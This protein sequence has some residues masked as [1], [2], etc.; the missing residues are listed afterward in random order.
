MVRYFWLPA[1]VLPLLVLLLLLAT[2]YAQPPQ[3]LNYPNVITFGAYSGSICYSN[4]VNVKSIIPVTTRTFSFTPATALQYVICYN[5]LPLHPFEV[6]LVGGGIGA[7]TLTSIV[8]TSASGKLY[9]T[10]NAYCT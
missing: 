1:R 6:S 3:S 2:G 4:S 5:N 7:T 9:V 10:C 8:V